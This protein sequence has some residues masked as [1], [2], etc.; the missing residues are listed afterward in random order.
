MPSVLFH[1]P[2]GHPLHPPLT[3]IAIGGYATAS[4]L[5][6]LGALG[7]SEDAMGK[8]AWLALL[9]GLSGAVF[10]ALTGLL[11][12]LLLPRGSVAFRT[13]VVHGLVNAAATVL[14]LLA[15]I[16]Q[17][18]GFR[19]GS[20]TTAGLVLTLLG[21]ALVSVGGY[22]G[23]TLVFRHGVRVEGDAR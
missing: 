3:D 21:L 23:G 7:V 22:L 2:S 9:V 18:D 5:A 1:G 19:D 8:G 14:F 10:A 17:Y 4:V 16:F 12:L 13:G 15:A 11:D 6:V 20:V